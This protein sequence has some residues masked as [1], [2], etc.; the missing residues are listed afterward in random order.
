MGTKEVNADTNMEVVEEK[1]VA[2]EAKQVDTETSQIKEEEPIVGIFEGSKE[3]KD[4]SS[5]YDEEDK[6]NM[7]EVE[8]KIVE[9]QSKSVEMG[10]IQSKE[11]EPIVGIFGGSK[12]RKDS[13]SDYDDDEGKDEDVVEEKVGEEVQINRTISSDYEEENEN[14]DKS[15]GDH[16]IEDAGEIK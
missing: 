15:S 14:D 4:S 2:E 5:D 10:D 8:E 9:E 12:D 3:R 7:E 6:E 1:F 16:E 11:E 13:S